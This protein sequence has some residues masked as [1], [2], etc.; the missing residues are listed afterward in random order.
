[1]Q[2]Y[3]DTTKERDTYSMPDAEVFQLTAREFAELDGDLMLEYSRKHEYRLATM[4]S[5]VWEK[6]IDAIVDENGIEGGWFFHFCF[7]GCLP[8]SSPFGPYPSRD[9]AVSA[10]RD[11]AND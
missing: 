3:T 4:N 9:A 8:E 5:K 11:M 6:M 2:F 10:A 1:M 7:P